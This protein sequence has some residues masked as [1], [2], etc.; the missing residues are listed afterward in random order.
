LYLDLSLYHVVGDAIG[1]R[2]ISGLSPQIRSFLGV[3]RLFI[4]TSPPLRIQ[5][6]QKPVRRAPEPEKILFIIEYY[7]PFL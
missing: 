4:V 7:F 6:P 1:I 5:N 2:P 3:L